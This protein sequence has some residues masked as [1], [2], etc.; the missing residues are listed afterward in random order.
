M[1][2]IQEAHR[3]IERHRAGLCTLQGVLLRE[4]RPRTSYVHHRS[5][6]QILTSSSCTADNVAEAKYGTQVCRSHICCKKR[7]RTDGVPRHGTRESYIPPA[8]WLLRTLIGVLLMLGI[9]LNSTTMERS[10]GG[11]IPNLR[12]SVSRKLKK[13]AGSGRQSSSTAC[14]YRIH[15]TQAQCTEHCAHGT[16]SS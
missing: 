11:L 12:P 14:L 1:G 9:G 2:E 3:R 4:A 10:Y 8:S 16:R 7:T 15:T 13:L 6:V 5:F